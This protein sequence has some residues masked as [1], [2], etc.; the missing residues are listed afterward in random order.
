MTKTTIGGL[1]LDV[2]VALVELDSYSDV[3]SARV[4]LKHIL[5]GL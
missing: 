2:I 1:A 5:K 4:T 3:K